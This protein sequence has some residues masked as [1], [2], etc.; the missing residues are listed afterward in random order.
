MS[1]ILAFC[2]ITAFI[3]QPLTADEAKP[4]L[5]RGHSQTPEEAAKELQQFVERGLS[6]GGGRV[7]RVPELDGQ[8]AVA[9]IRIHRRERHVAH[10]PGAR[11]ARIGRRVEGGGGGRRG[12]EE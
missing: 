3:I 4:K 7:D 2:V 6:D 11:G 1:R 5:R 9:A 12:P 10:A 8:G